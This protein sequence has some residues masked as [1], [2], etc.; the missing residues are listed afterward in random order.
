MNL[1]R[2][3]KIDLNLLVALHILLEEGSVSKAATKLSITQPAM[4]KTLGRLRETFDDPLFVR[5]KRGV[6]PT[7]RAIGLGAE[8]KVTL[9]QIDGLLDA[10]E[11]LPASYR[12]QITLAISEYVGFTLLPPLSARLQSS[13]PKLRLRTITRAERQ[14]DQLAN[15]ELDFAIQI[16]REDY[17]PEFSVFPLADSPLAIFVRQDHPL[18]QLTLT[19]EMI[20]QYPHIA[21]YVAD[22][23]ELIG[24]QV[25]AKELFESDKGILE[26]SHLLTAFEILRETDYLLICPAYLARNEGATRDIVALTLPVD[27]TFSVQYSLIAHRRTDH[28]PM[29]RWLWQEI[30]DTVQAMR[31]R[32]VHRG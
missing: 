14:L 28:S 20:R 31:F 12:G 5:S 29:H 26:T 30:I 13:A 4:S 21:L 15:G 2:L 7:P 27:L 8:L 23:E 18:V 16:Q 11:F 24:G 22:R 32:T 6:Q 1:S 25:L 10:G 17:A 9:E 19:K 3:A